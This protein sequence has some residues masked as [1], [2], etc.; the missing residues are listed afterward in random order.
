MVQISKES[1]IALSANLTISTITARDI[2]DVWN[3]E[4]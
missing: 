3:F 4:Q 1:I 2:L